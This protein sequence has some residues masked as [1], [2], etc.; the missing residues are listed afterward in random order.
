MKRKYFEPQL[1][2]VEV[3][4]DDLMGQS[5]FNQNLDAQD[6]EP[7]DEEYDGEFGTNGAFWEDYYSKTQF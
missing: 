1:K 2:F 6:I 7:T 3:E 4:T 5:K